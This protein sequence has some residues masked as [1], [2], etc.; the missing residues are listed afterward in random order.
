MVGLLEIT[1]AAL[2]DIPGLPA[3]WLNRYGTAGI[4]KGRRASYRRGQAGLYQYLNTP[5]ETMDPMNMDV[6][7]SVENQMTGD[8]SRD[9]FNEEHKDVEE[10]TSGDDCSQVPGCKILGFYC[11]SRVHRYVVLILSLQLTS[12]LLLT[13]FV[14]SAT[15]NPAALRS[16]VH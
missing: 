10:D 9:E 14:N 12:L 13:C 4:L 2:S 6:M 7:L 1:T 16:S 5:F 8:S 3:E 15:T 11:L